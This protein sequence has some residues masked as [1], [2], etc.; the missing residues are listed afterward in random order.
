M[1]RAGRSL[2]GRW[3]DRFYLRNSSLS[4]GETSSGSGKCVGALAGQDLGLGENVWLLGDRCV[5]CSARRAG[6]EEVL[7]ARDS[8]MKNVYS[9]FSF[10]K[11]EVG[12][13]SLK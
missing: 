6:R 3:T 10:D 7:M 4:L 5:R 13:A 1:S 12:F 2:P 9:A 11:N 8:F